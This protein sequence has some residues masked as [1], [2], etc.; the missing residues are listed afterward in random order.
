[1]FTNG[2]RYFTNGIC[3]ISLFC[4]SCLYGNHEYH[5]SHEWLD[6]CD[7]DEGDEAPRNY[8]AYGEFGGYA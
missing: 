7:L 2:K 3:L 5:P 4:S 1:M 6:Y 8:D